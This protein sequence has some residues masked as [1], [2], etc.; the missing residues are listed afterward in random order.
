MHGTRTRHTGPSTTQALARD[1]ELA[2]QH[3]AGW[4]LAD[5]YSDMPWLAVN[6]RWQR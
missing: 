3:A 1:D 6:K 4:L 2:F 5:S